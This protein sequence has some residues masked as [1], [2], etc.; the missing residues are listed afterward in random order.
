MFKSILY[1][2]ICILS[3]ASCTKSGYDEA[4]VY[5]SNFNTGDKTGLDGAILYKYNG[6]N[7]IGR[8]NN[9][10]FTQNNMPTT[11]NNIFKADGGVENQGFI[12][13]NRGNGG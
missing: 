1:T 5:N 12:E 4:V 8:Y 13:Q 10:G 3:F 9:G 2:T 11:N 7:I 6:A